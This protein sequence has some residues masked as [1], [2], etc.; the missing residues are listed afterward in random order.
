M[1]HHD[2]F[3]LHSVSAFQN[4]RAKRTLMSQIHAMTSTGS[5]PSFALAE[6]AIL[7]RNRYV[8]EQLLW[9]GV[10]PSKKATALQEPNKMIE[11][12]NEAELLTVEKMKAKLAA[13]KASKP[14]KK[15][16]SGG[17]GSKVDDGSAD[18]ENIGAQT[19]QNSVSSPKN[20]KS[21]SFDDLPIA[22]WPIP[23]CRREVAPTV[24]QTI[25][26]NRTAAEALVSLSENSGR[27]NN[28][29]SR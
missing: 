19:S 15:R 26:C 11:A 8:V 24:L 25:D 21:R 4:Q 1:I 18:K 7:M 16:V 17:K 10:G 6:I 2:T 27:G 20:R 23:Y 29:A 13:M 22:Q 28:S 14:S 12:G 9:N 3:N 5:R